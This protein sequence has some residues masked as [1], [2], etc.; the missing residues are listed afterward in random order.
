[1]KE[2]VF[3]KLVKGTKEAIAIERGESS[4][5]LYTIYFE[6]HEMQA[7]RNRLGLTQRRMSEI[8]AIP[9]ATIR[10]WEQG[11]RTPDRAAMALYQILDKDPAAA[12]AAF[13]ASR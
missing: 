3:G 2:E 13:P 10:H 4:D 12:L 1:M 11:T 5:G 6:A 7:V 8:L 9:I